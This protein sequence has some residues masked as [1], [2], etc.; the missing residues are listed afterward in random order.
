[1]KLKLHSFQEQVEKIRV[2]NH[3]IDENNDKIQ[4]IN[5]TMQHAKDLIQ[6]KAKSDIQ[7]LE[8][9]AESAIIQLEMFNHCTH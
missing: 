8:Q 9:E 6:R 3:E 7:L 2:L 1:M 4:V 5:A